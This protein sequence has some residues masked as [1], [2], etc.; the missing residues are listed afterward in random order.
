MHLWAN[1]HGLG[2]NHDKVEAPDSISKYP[3]MFAN[4]KSATNFDQGQG[5]HVLGCLCLS[6]YDLP[7]AAK[8][9]G[10]QADPIDT[11]L[12]SRQR[13]ACRIPS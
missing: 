10:V 12:T 7:D 8:I 9:A 5:G 1:S 2:R 4:P 3:D 6:S 13:D 11:A